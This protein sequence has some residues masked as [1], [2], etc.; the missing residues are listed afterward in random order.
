MKAA[1]VREFGKAPEYGE[2]AEP[3]PA[4]G[5]VVATIRAA[6]VSNLVRLVAA[7]KHYSSAA[8]PPMIAGVD[9]VAE[10]ADKPLL[11]LQEYR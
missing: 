1:V 11:V 3:D 4:E 8:K 2:F 5:E 10:L 6:A 7:G 9:G